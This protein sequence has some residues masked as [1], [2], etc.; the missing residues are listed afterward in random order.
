MARDATFVRMGIA[1]SARSYGRRRSAQRG[2]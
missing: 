2:R 1:R